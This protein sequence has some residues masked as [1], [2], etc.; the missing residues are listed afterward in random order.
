VPVTPAT[1]MQSP[2]QPKP[3]ATHSIA[4]HLWHDESGQDLIEYALLGA[5]IALSA[6]TAMKGLGTKISSSFTSVGSTLTSSV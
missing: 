3:T 5:L 2:K 1:H 4:M 6:V